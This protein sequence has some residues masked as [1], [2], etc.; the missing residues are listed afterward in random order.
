MRLDLFVNL[1]VKSSLT[2]KEDG[3]D[4][5]NLLFECLSGIEPQR[6]GNYEPIKKQFLPGHLEAALESWQWPFLWKRTKPSVQGAVWQDGGPERDHGWVTFQGSSTAVNT[7][8][9]VR[10]LQSASIRFNADFAFTHLLT[11]EEIKRAFLS[12]TAFSLRTDGSG[13]YHMTV[14]PNMLRRYIP[15]LYWGVVWGP[16]YIEHFGRQ[17]ILSAPAYIVQ[18]LDASHIYMQVSQDLADLNSK[19]DELEQRR[20]AIRAH[21]NLDSFFDAEKGS[22]YHYNTPKFSFA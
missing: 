20:G 5:L 19:P 1:A 12:G 4:F 11:S 8:K 14:P 18:E 16:A 3:K 9:I 6:Y 13:P 21:L 17:T 2:S 22:D 10:F 15:D 7:T